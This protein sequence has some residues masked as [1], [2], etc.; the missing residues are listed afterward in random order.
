MDEGRVA[1]L[2][3]V[4]RIARA[5]AEFVRAHTGMPIGGVA[6]V[7]HPEPIG[8]LV[9]VELARYPQ[10]WAAAGHPHAVFPT[11]YEEL[12]R[13]TDGTAAEVGDGP[14][15]AP[16]GAPGAVPHDQGAALR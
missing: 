2:L 5:S 11:S 13:I 12:L 6:P 3:G 10:V 1:T 16:V 14:G 7:G 4:P 15:E 8:T 9:D